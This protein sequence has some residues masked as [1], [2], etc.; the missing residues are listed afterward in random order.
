M[1]ED[2]MYVLT[3]ATALGCGVVAGVFFAFST[4]VMQG[5]ARA[6]VPHGIAAMQSINIWALTPVFMTVLFGTGAAAALLGVAALR[7]LAEPRSVWLLAGSLLYILGVIV[8][9]MVCN[10]P[11]NN[12]LAKVDPASEEGARVWADY[13]VTWTRWNHVR[14]VTALA[15]AAALSLTL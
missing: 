14:T 11:R 6:P 10:V 8:V 5:L 13:V 9:T 3:L 4:F 12:R 15:A 2:W 7:S 1:S